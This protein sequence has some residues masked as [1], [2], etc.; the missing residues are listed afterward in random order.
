VVN[1]QPV[2]LPRRITPLRPRVRSESRSANSSRSMAS[3]RRRAAT[4]FAAPWSRL[5]PGSTPITAGSAPS[6]QRSTNAL[7]FVRT[8]IGA[9]NQSEGVW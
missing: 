7:E 5:D 6:A 1:S 4:S 8:L 3:R 2:I 9:P